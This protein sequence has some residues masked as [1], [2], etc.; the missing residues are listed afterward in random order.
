MLAKLPPLV[1][2]PLKY[3][4]LGGIL[5]GI[6]VFTLYYIGRFPYVPVERTVL[7]AIFIF[8][9]VKELRDYRLGGSLFFWQGL[10]AGI[11]CYVTMALVAAFMIWLWGQ[12]DDAYVNHYVT[13]VSNQL[14][15]N[16]EEIEKQVGKE[17][18]ALQ[19]EKLPSTT[20]SDLALDYVLKSMFI[21]IFLTIVISVILRR[22]P[23][24]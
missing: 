8:F 5:A 9:A 21:G 20:I 14:E 6:L 15:T 13:M 11:I 2:V 12:W 22:Q 23:K 19:L 1:G 17:D 7:F 3:G 18:L 10:A 4:V 24:T 16:R